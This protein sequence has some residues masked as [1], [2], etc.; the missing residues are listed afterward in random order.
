MSIFDIF[1]KK[2]VAPEPTEQEEKS[3]TIPSVVPTESSEKEDNGASHK[4]PVQS[5]PQP[6]SFSTEENKQ[7]SKPIEI[8]KDGKSH[9][10]N[11]IILDESGSMM[12]LRDSTVSGLQETI[13]TIRQAQKEFGE[14]QQHYL[15]LV[16]FDS[17]GRGNIPVRT[18]ID[19]VPIQEQAFDNIPYHPSGCTPLYDAMGQSITRLHELIKD[20]EDA[21][22][23]VTVITDG[24]EN[25]S[26]EY[27][28]K[29]LRAM[30][31]N[32]KSEGWTFSYMGSAHDVKS[33]TD[34]LSIDNVMEFSH[35]C[36]GAR[37]SWEHERSSKMRYYRTMMSEWDNLKGLSASDRRKLK[38]TLAKGYYQ[39]HVTPDFVNTLQ[40]NEIF[41]FG[42]DPLGR[43]TGAAGQYAVDHFGAIIGQGEGLQGQ[44]YAIPTT[45]S[46][47]EVPEHIRQFI[48]YAEA[49]P[50]K[51]FLITE[52]GCGGAGFSPDEIAPLFGDC[53][54]LE[55]ISLPASFWHVLGINMMN[56]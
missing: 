15:T 6:C 26:Q 21:S 5:A 45:C 28:G 23:V 41:V 47:Q 18:V 55:N 14:S 50:E 33:V 49:H 16:T 43:H 25:A 39:G 56:I 48:R 52:V 11:L 2:P 17:P 27:S 53:I 30:I 19:T 1:K 37:N 36:T 32:L 51:K 20:D 31:E 13:N 54:H 9:I 12:S 10:F 46:P 3:V 24:L 44:C 38:S 40:P 22:A 35:D 7:E 8:T 29:Q 34:L 42:T 4:D